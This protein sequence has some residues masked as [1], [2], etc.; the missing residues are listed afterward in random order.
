MAHRCPSLPRRSGSLTGRSLLGSWPRLPG[1]RPPSRSRRCRTWALRATFAGQLMI[2]AKAKP[3]SHFLDL[4]SPAA[5]WAR[6]EALIIEKT[7]WTFDD[8]DA[9]DVDRVMQAVAVWN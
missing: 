2:L 1:A 4:V 7:G 9:Q 3:D 5:K 8:L 6:T